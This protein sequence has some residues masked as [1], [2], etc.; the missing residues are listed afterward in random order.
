MSGIEIAGIVLGSFPILLKCLNHYRDGFRPLEEWWDFR[1]HSVAF[2]DDIRHQMM[3]Y[4]EN[5]IRLLGPIAANMRDLHDLIRNP[6][7]QRWHDGNLE[8]PLRQRLG[9]EYDR[10]FRIVERM[11]EV[12]A[13]LEVLLQIDDGTVALLVSPSQGT[14]WQWYFKR[15]RISFSREKHRNVRKLA[16]YNQELHEIL[17]YSERITSASVSDKRVALDLE[18]AESDSRLHAPT[19]AVGLFGSIRQ[20][21]CGIYNRLNQRR[22]YDSTCPPET[23]A[24]RD[25]ARL[26]FSPLSISVSGNVLFILGSDSEFP[27]TTLQQFRINMATGAT[28]APMPDMSLAQKSALLASVQQAL[29]GDNRA[30]MRQEKP[31]SLPSLRLQASIPSLK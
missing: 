2:V 11:R 23:Y 17:G 16:A 25:A 7:D 12:V 3:R 4:N 30:T 31:G 8:V 19:R 29:I 20:Q 26:N 18:L 22:K 9:S 28:P 14:P 27:S 10:F 24:A 21:A 6:T 5:L 13:D 1:T 15:M